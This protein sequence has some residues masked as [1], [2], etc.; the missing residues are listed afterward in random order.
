M[1][2][3]HKLGCDEA[4]QRII[5]LLNETKAKFGDKVSDVRENWDGNK[6]DFSFKAMGLSVSGNFEVQPTLVNGELVLPFAA[7]PM[8]SQIERDLNTKARELLT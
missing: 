2:V 6:A 5:R 1:S 8:K 7:L 4:K 3:P